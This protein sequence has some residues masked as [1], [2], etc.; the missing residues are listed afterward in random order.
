MEKNLTMW[1]KIANKI[2]QLVITL[3]PE[4]REFTKKKKFDLKKNVF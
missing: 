2:I 3:L 1:R 4:K